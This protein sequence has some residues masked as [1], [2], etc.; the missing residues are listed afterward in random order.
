[1]PWNWFEWAFFYWVL[2]DFCCVLMVAGVAA[3]L[4]ERSLN[5]AVAGNDGRAL[6]RMN[7]WALLGAVCLLTFTDIKETTMS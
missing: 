1:M 4:F 5:G 6:V 2:L 3:V 7:Y